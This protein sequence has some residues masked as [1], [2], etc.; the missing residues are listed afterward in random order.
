[1]SKRSYALVLIVAAVIV[2]AAIAAHQPGGSRWLARLGSAI[3][4]H[5]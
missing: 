2:A 1:M 3:H 5:R 4:G